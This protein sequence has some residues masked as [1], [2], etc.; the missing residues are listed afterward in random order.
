MNLATLPIAHSARVVTLHLDKVEARFVRAVGIFEKE[1]VTVLRR[2][3]FGGPIHLRTSSGGEF[4]LDLALA[5]AIEVEVAG[6]RQAK[7]GVSE[8]ST[9]EAAE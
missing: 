7:S 5:R 4:A 3:P 6:L 9:R 2:A 8:E 1:E